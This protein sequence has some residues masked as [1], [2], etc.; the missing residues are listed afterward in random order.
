MLACGKSVFVSERGLISTQWT[1]YSEN[2]K[3]I[4]YSAVPT[5]DITAETVTVGGF[6]L[7]QKDTAGVVTTATR[8]LAI[9]K[10]ATWYTYGWDLSKNICEAYGQHGYI[11]TAYTYTPYGQVTASGGTEQTFQW[12]SEF[13]P[14]NIQAVI[15]LF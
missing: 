12:S 13:Q 15:C 9:Q 8:P 4:Q 11:R 5:S 7:S 1:E 3:R 14:A 10:D 2:T 6:A